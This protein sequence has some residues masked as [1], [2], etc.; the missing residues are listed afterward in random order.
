[1]VE[2]GLG[3]ENVYTFIC[4]VGDT[5]EIC[6]PLGY[7]PVSWGEGKDPSIYLNGF[8]ILYPELGKF[9]GSPG[10]RCV[11]YVHEQSGSQVIQYMSVGLGTV[12]F[13]A[14]LEGIIIHDHASIPQGGPAF[15]TYYAELP[16]DAG[17]ET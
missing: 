15:A 9:D 12:I 11:N 16:E 10:N 13:Y 14:V 3:S 8:R 2:L 1:M 17:E 4:S 6:R 5:V 7:P